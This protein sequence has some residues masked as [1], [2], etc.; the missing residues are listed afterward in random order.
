MIEELFAFQPMSKQKMRSTSLIAAGLGIAIFA[1]MTLIQALD[2]PGFWEVG[3]WLPNLGNNSSPLPGLLLYAL[4]GWVFI[5]G[6]RETGNVPSSFN[7]STPISEASSPRFGFWITCIG[8]AG[9]TAYFTALPT[10]NV[11]GPA[12]SAAWLI[13]ILLLIISVT[14]EIRWKPATFQHIMDWLGTHLPEIL[15]IAVLVSVAFMV[16]FW[17]IELHPYSFVNDEGQMG[18]NG[19]CI[20][21]GPC[22][23]LF[24]MGWAGQPMLA[25]LPTGISV[26][27]L[28]RTALAVRL[29]SVII[30]TLAVLAVYIFTREVI[31]KKEAWVAMALLATLPVNVHFS[32][33]G[34]DNIVDSLSTTAILGFLFIGMKRN[35]TVSFLIAGI[36]GGLCMYTYPGT[37]LAPIIGLGGIAYVALRTQGFLKAQIR[38]IATFILALIVTAAPIAGYFIANPNFFFARM[39]SEGIFQNH[40]FEG[41]VK[42]GGSALAF[43]TEQF[44]R[45]SLVYILTP[46]PSNFFSSPK[47]FIPALAAIFFVLGLAYTIWRI[48]EE[49]YLVLFI[50][51]WAA[52]ILGST[53]T[54]G[55]PSSQ[56]M[57]MSTPALVIIT[58][59]GVC[60]VIENIPP[61]G[62]ITGRLQ[63]LALVFFVTLVG[64]ANI[65]FYH[66]EYRIGH[67]F[68]DPTNELTYE[69]APLIS[70]LHQ[71]GRFYIMA[72]PGVPF[73]AFPSFDFFSPDVEKAYFDE[74][75]PQSLANLQKDKDALFIAT[76][77]RLDDLKKLAALIPGGEWREVQRR[78]QP[79]NMLYY[80]YKIKQSDLQAFKP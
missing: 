73:L 46:A 17:N 70:Q 11:N 47:P 36:L 40:V 56:R 41:A 69:T 3:G 29:I 58:A 8:L 26:A 44:M 64:Y 30:G 22:N 35:S 18:L 80:S 55:P 54:G 66:F 78:Y 51:F 34:V 5:R 67:Y 6:L 39:N 4:A 79:A 52:I 63:I 13:N 59:I 24:S 76:P 37:R 45:S 16:R 75:S 2:Q 60:K 14:T 19:I 27:I 38:N 48:K 72:A 10:A 12:L 9:L 28:G 33:L 32:R 1:Q 57:L 42:S 21:Q 71:T 53:I 68:E 62:N 49:R 23:S 7:I 65:S 25:F 31:G 50:W 77:D 15:G 43:L 20:A 61:I 74:V